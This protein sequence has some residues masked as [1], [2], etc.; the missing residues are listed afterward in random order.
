[1]S[2]LEKAEFVRELIRYLDER[3]L[4]EEGDK[5]FLPRNASKSKVGKVKSR[6]P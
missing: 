3:I 4:S 2:Q 5:Q 1:M 6:Q